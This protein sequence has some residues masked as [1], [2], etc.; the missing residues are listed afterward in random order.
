MG[1]VYRKE[2]K[3]SMSL[4]DEIR[5]EKQRLQAEI[6]DSRNRAKMEKML[7]DAD[8]EYSKIVSKPDSDLEELIKEVL[9]KLRFT[10]GK[11]VKELPDGSIRARE[12]KGRFYR[13]VDGQRHPWDEQQCEQPNDYSCDIRYYED[14]YESYHATAYIWI[15]RDGSVAFDYPTYS[16]GTRTHINLRKELIKT[17]A[18]FEVHNIESKPKSNPQNIQKSKSAGGCYIATAVYGSYDCP[19]VWVLRRYRDYVLKSTWYGKIFIKIYYTVSPILVKLF[20]KNEWFQSF[21]KKRLDKIADDLKKRGI[22][23]EPYVDR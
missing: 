11:I 17:I 10:S 23:D 5:Q 2:G 19:E 16:Y 9:P 7:K 6:D 15:F 21:F 1:V 20:G 12:P 18:Y 22:N 14:E 13:G 4:D 8:M 3:K